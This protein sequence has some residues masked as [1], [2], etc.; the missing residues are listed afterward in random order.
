M[1]FLFQWSNKRKALQLLIV[2]LAAIVP[3][4][5]VG[6]GIAASFA[7]AEQYDTTTSVINDMTAK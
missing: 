7:L 3:D 6:I 4:F 1:K 5:D 2:T